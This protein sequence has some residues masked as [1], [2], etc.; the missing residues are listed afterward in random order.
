M[1]AL[2]VLMLAVIEVI[3]LPTPAVEAASSS[4]TTTANTEM[5]LHQDGRDDS[6]DDDNTYISVGTTNRLRTRIITTRKTMP[7]NVVVPS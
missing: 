6:N 5:M 7:M 4:S 1:V 2:T 3:A